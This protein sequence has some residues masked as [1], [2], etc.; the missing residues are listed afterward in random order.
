MEAWGKRHRRGA[1][2][3]LHY[4][5][6]SNSPGPIL[7]SL[8]RRAT[9]VLMKN[10]QALERKNHHLSGDVQ[11]SWSRKTPVCAAVGIHPE[12]QMKWI[13]N[14][15]PNDISAKMIILFLL[16]NRLVSYCRVE[17]TLRHVGGLHATREDI[18]DADMR[19]ECIQTMR[20][21]FG[22]L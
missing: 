3:Y 1:R 10:I 18:E 4:G 15:V 14:L 13:S 19:R 11:L 20:N 22:L 12:I 5:Q 9:P 2:P 21:W 7:I 8:D 16:S 17:S 6:L